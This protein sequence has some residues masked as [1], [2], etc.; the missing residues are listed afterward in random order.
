MS[1]KHTPGPWHWYGA[2]SQRHLHDS[3]SNSF[4][5][6]SMPNSA[7]YHADAKLIA[8]APE[9]AEALRAINLM[10]LPDSPGGQPT[11]ASIKRARELA[12]AAL[13]KAG[14]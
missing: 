10:L 7:A 3:N 5:Q 6:V 11:A 1:T 13:A 9:M 4:A 14:L 8:A 12:H 2:R